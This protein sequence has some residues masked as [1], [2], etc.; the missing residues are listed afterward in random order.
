MFLAQQKLFFYNLDAILNFNWDTSLINDLILVIKIMCNVP[1][2]CETLWIGALHIIQ[3]N[4]EFV[5]LKLVPLF[6][7][8]YL[9][10][11]CRIYRFRIVSNINL[12]L[13]IMHFVFN[14][15]CSYF[16][17]ISLFKLNSI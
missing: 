4:S 13:S 7:L 2:Y 3:A 9:S 10:L 1:I 17:I 12:L 11:N 14:G 15:I 5:T 16:N 8:S 6:K